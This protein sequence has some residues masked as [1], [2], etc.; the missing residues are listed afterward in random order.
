MR[1]VRANCDRC[2]EPME[3]VNVGEQGA[4]RWWCRRCALGQVRWGD[5]EDADLIPTG[6]PRCHCSEC[7]AERAHGEVYPSYGF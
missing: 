1:I 5:C 7:R 2:R 6:G 3:L 4:S